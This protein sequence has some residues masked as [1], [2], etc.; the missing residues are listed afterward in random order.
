MDLCQW[1]G[2]A[3]TWPREGL[4]N[5]RALDLSRVQIEIAWPSWSGAFLLAL[6]SVQTR[7]SA[8]AWE[9]T[10]TLDPFLNHHAFRIWHNIHAGWQ[11][12]LSRL[13]LAQLPVEPPCHGRI[14]PALVGS[15][16][17]P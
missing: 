5:T 14:G 12:A 2:I 6:P 3:L 8:L 4:A 11:A 10:S 17:A 16:V 15:S 9:A 1:E 13:L 7:K